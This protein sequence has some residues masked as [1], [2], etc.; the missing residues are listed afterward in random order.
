MLI[1]KPNGTKKSYEI[2]SGILKKRKDTIM[3]NNVY[4]TGQHLS[5]EKR[6]DIQNV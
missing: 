3:E 5:S 2:R 1:Y 6:F 4:G